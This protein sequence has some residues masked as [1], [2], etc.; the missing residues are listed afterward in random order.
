M[1]EEEHTSFQPHYLTISEIRQM[2]REKDKPLN[3]DTILATLAPLAGTSF[4]KRMMQELAEIIPVRPPT[5]L[6]LYGALYHRVIDT[7]V[8]KDAQRID[9]ATRCTFQLSGLNVPS[10]NVY[11]TEWIEPDELMLREYRRDWLYHDYNH[12]HNAASHRASQFHFYKRGSLRGV[13]SFS[14]LDYEDLRFFHHA[15]LEEGVLA[16]TFFTDKKRSPIPSLDPR[17][18]LFQT[19]LPLVYVSPQ[20][21]LEKAQPKPSL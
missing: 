2:Y 7:W 6:D 10:E 9:E 15:I 18:F 19:S 8:W 11:A 5:A 12:R 1:V 3:A 17:Q 4:F 20:F 21:S 13:L 16:H 14:L